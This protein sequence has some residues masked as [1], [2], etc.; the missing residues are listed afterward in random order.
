MAEWACVGRDVGSAVHCTCGAVR[1]AARARLV[2]CCWFAGHLNGDIAYEKMLL[3]FDF[4][5]DVLAS[6]PAHEYV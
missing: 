2:L 6:L 1:E 3:H 4:E 5:L